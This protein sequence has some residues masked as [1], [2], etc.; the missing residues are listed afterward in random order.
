LVWRHRHPAGRGREA[1]THLQRLAQL[2]ENAPEGL[3]LNGGVSEVTGDDLQPTEYVINVLELR[4]D[5]LL[6]DLRQLALF[7]VQAAAGEHY[8]LHVGS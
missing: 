3:E 6:R 8:I 5:D 2:F 4:R 7:A 1:R